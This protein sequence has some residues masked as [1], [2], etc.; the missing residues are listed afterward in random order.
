[1]KSFK[2]KKKADG[3]FLFSM[4]YLLLIIIIEKVDPQYLSAFFYRIVK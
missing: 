3:E 1:M 2:W 4:Y